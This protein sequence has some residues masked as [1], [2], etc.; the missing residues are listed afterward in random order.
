MIAWTLLPLVVHDLAARP[1][2]QR[3]QAGVRPVRQKPDRPVREQPI[4]PARMDTPEVMR[5]THVAISGAI[6]LRKQAGQT[7]TGVDSEVP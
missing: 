2:C 4:S 7:M 3:R 5:V 6:I 1:C